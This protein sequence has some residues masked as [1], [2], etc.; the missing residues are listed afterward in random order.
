MKKEMSNHEL[1][2]IRNIIKK[3]DICM[4]T[5]IGDGGSPHTRPMSNNKDVEFDGDLWFFTY[6]QTYKTFEIR[7]TN[8][9]SVAFSSVSDS[10]YLVISGTAEIIKDRRKIEE[11]WKPALKAW[12]PEGLEEPDLAL[13]KVRSESAEIWQGPTNFISKAWHFAKALATGEMFEGQHSEVAF[14]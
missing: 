5:T 1:E 3:I 14:R 13:I 11:L 9:V 7:N 8:A 4:L 12:F 2:E 6:G 10:T